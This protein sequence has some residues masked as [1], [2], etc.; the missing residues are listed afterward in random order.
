MAPSLPQLERF[1]YSHYF[2]S[3]LR[4]AFGVL[5]LPLLFMGVF[6]LYAAGIVVAFGAACVAILDQPGG[7]RR[8]GTNG[9]LAALLLCSLTVGITGLA[10][11][12]IWLTW[13]VVPALAF[14]FSMFAV[15]GKQGGTLGFAC[16]LIMTLTMRTPLQP[17]EVLEHTAYS[18]LG[19]LY[20]FVFSYLTH[21]LM[22]HR[23]EQ[24]TLS[25]ALYA[26]ADYMQARSDF[27]DINIDLEDSYRRLISTQTTM[28]DA[29]Q[30]ARDTVLRE[31]PRGGRRGDALRAGSLNIFI[32]MVA[33]LDTLVATHTDYTTLRQRLPD[34]DVMVFARD[35][36]RKL[37]LNVSR[38]ALNIA[39]K[40]R[41]QERNSVKAEL[42]AIE[43]ELE[44]YRRDGMDTREPEIYALLVQILRRLRNATRLVDR[45]AD[46]A[47]HAPSSMLVD[48]R[49]ERSLDRFLSRQRW[50]VGMI[51]SNLR[52]DSAICRFACRVTLA[53]VL[54]MGLSTLLTHTKALS[55]VAEGLSAHTYW[56][57]L[58]IIVI[59]KPG[60]AI[61]RKRNTW[62]LMGTLAGCVLALALFE[63]TTN[64]NV[65][66]LALVVASVFAYSLVLVNYMLAA[67]FNTLFVLL[68]FHF[69]FPNNTFVIGERLIDTLIGCAL[70]LLASYILPWWEHRAVV[71]L[72]DAL[73]RANRDMLRAGVRYAN[74]ARRKA[75]ATHL[76]TQAGPVRPEDD[77]RSDQARL[78]TEE[79]EAEI[80]WRLAR[81]NMHIAFS[82]F[83]A[84]FQRMMDEPASRQRNVASLN[85]L[86]IQNHILAS[87]VSNAVP[88]LA[89]LP[90]VPPGIQASIDAVEAALDDRDAQ[91]PASIETDGELAA[92]AYPVRQMVK[93]ATLVQQEMRG[94]VPATQATDTA[95]PSAPAEHQLVSR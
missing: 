85:N 25:A 35:A 73:R 19:S 23:E 86:L 2:L 41:Q 1:F 95:T 80:R 12:S 72:A 89:A 11:S 62:R 76:A 30:A 93:A 57:I 36:L 88:L 87:Q 32:D 84:A 38:V 54:A 64:R 63:A 18:F 6:Q 83:A 55:V 58:T 7:P 44:T 28:T 39:R 20:Y 10:S 45:I 22:W 40:R 16:L 21:R 77:T 82:N 61:T 4:Q 34:S 29:H 90:Q 27:Y 13:L 53:I 48:E 9:M 67:M 70:A 47:G 42:R 66:L 50:Q 65:Y 8:Y 46:H 37:S 94:L 51:T 14:L 60:F 59:M 5:S 79:H 52:L 24:Q 15:Y 91:A 71:S 74:L 33:L 68:A 26:T 17:Q 78:E 31:L 43:Y 3:G 56:I 81:K 69:M 75:A 92:L 49:L